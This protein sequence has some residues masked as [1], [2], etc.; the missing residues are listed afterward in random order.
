[1]GRPA[2]SAGKD[3]RQAILD[4]ALDLFSEKGFA[5]GSMRQ[6][7]LRVGVQGSALYHHFPS[8]EDLMRALIREAGPGQAARLADLDVEAE[9]KSGVRPFLRKLTHTLIGSWSSPRSRKLMRLVLAE[10][11]KLGR[12]EISPVREIDNA[13]ATLSGLFAGLMQQ[14]LIRKGDPQAA[15]RAFIAPL[16]LLRVRYTL[17]GNTV[18]VREM[19]RIAD[20]QIDFFVEVLAP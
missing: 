6:L 1:M 20:Q 9:L 4:A 11:P 3:T 7:A 18:D 12:T 2:A 14:G 13:L 5:G 17:I 10:G 15:A 8:K 16:I 19:K